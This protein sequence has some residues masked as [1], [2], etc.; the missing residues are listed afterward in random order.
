MQQWA[1]LE[2]RENADLESLRKSRVQL[3]VQVKKLEAENEEIEKQRAADEA[4]AEKLKLKLDKFKDAWEAH[5][6]SMILFPLLFCHS[7]AP[8]VGNGDRTS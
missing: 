2:N 4:R 1:K 5:A 8:V 3:E 6:V 7:Y